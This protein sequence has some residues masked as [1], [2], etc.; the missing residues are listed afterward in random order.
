[1][2]HGTFA[3]NEL[4]TDDIE[5]C[6]RFYAELFGWTLKDLTG[7]M[8]TYVVFVQ[9]GRQVA[10]MMK[11]P[12]DEDVSTGWYAYVAVDDVDRVAARIAG[13]G[14]KILREPFDIPDVGRTCVLVDPCGATLMIMTLARKE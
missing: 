11:P 12:D 10:G 7:P 9:D 5:A 3:W 13:L 14:G 1:M 2:Q 4:I 8:G 6:G